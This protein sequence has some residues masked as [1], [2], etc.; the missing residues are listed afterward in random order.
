MKALNERL[1]DI[2]V[3]LLVAGILWG[4]GSMTLANIRLGEMN[5]TLTAM[6][7][8]LQKLSTT[9]E[10]HEVRIEAAEIFIA[11]YKAVKAFESR[12]ILVR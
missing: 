3:Y 1:G 2:V 8:D 10:G 6:R 11:E 12:V 5:V 4:A 9:V 7:T